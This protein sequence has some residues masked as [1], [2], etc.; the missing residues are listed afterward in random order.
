MFAPQLKAEPLSYAVYLPEWSGKLA[1][2]RDNFAQ[3]GFVRVA[4]ES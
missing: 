2:Q 1:L 3:D 4:S